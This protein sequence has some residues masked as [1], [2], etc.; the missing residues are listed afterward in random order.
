[1]KVIDF[2]LSRKDGVSE[3]SKAQEMEQ[4]LGLLDKVEGKA[5]KL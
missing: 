2:G 5:L 1:V 3:E 4:V